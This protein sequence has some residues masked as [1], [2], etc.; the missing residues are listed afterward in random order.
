MDIKQLGRNLNEH[1]K[2][3]TTKII[4]RSDEITEIIESLSRMTKNNPV[5]VGPPGVG[6]TA[7]VEGLAK[8]MNDGDIPPNLREY[9]IHEITINALTAGSQFRGDLE[10][11]VDA[12]LKYASNPDNKVILFIDEI[13]TLLSNDMD[14]KIA[15]TFKP[16]MS[17]GEI[18][19]IGA[20][21]LDEFV[22]IEK[23]KA[24]ERR[25]Q[26]IRIDEPTTSESITIL[27]GIKERFEIF[28]SIIIPD[29]VIVKTVEWSNRYMANKYQPDKSIDLIDHACS[30]I[31]TSLNS[32][33]I[34][35]IKEEEKLYELNIMLN[36]ADESK[37]DNIKIAI[38]ESEEKIDVLSAKFKKINEGA[39]KLSEIKVMLEKAQADVD[40]F[41]KEGNFSKAA[42]IL[43]DKIPALKKEIANM[44]KEQTDKEDLPILT[45]DDIA[46]VLYKITGIPVS[47]VT[48]K[49]DDKV[50][51][52]KDYLSS[53]VIGQDDAVVAIANS[54]TVAQANIVR[55]NGPIASFLFAGA[56]GTGKTEIAKRLNEFMFE[57]NKDI[58]RFDMSEYSERHKVSNLLGSPKGYVNSEE[59]GLLTEAVKRKPYSIVLFDEIE[60]A[61]T[62][63]LDIL[64]Q[65]LDEGRLTDS[66]GTVVDFK[67]TI[68]IA[69]T[70]LGTKESKV[71]KLGKAELI[72]II[73]RATRPEFV[74]R[75]SDVV[76]FNELS[77]KDY[78]DILELRIN[79]FQNQISEKGIKLE[80]SRADI[81]EIVDSIYE[82]ELGARPINRFV[83]NTLEFE[84]AKAFLSG[85]KN[86]INI[87]KVINPK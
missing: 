62:S 35:L 45:T 43:I 58:I 86:T 63:A 57:E 8:A 68:I 36:S 34:E 65:V 53:K 20:T 6:K 26:K 72:K 73:S 23:D 29:D 37:K 11:K 28:H 69:T 50:A 32:K 82:P 46:Q 41:K 16:Y 9:Q 25:M 4:G 33:P 52:V 81:E 85:D 77:K 19:I 44:E 42:D 80:Y 78:F 12:L 7:I 79:E 48:S 13:H 60:K 74:N 22:I 30:R 24:L 3:V 71:M 51:G 66:K 75:F 18:K 5:L 67:N 87:K 84:V 21:T 64:L 31:N 61:H 17:R 47:K 54:M 70:N 27:R 59:G 83:K 49:K 10:K 38:K 56:T 2:K 76:W 15:Q 40:K 55:R 39:Q 14:G 1:V